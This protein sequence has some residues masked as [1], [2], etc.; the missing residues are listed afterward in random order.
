MIDLIFGVGVIVAHADKHDIVY[1][2]VISKNTQKGPNFRPP[3]GVEN[4]KG[5]QLQ[6]GGASSPDIVTRDS[7]LEPA[8]GSAGGSAPKPNYRL[9]LCARHLPLCLIPGSA[10]E[11]PCDRK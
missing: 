7:A 3:S 9:M 10:P 4:L 8:G 1:V 6:G 2:V 5:F 11:Y